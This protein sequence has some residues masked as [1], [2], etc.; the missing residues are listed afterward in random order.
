MS[1][2]ITIANV[3]EFPPNTIRYVTTEDD[4]SIL[5]SNINGAYYAIENMCTHDGGT[6]SE[7]HLEND[8]IVCPRHGAHFCLRNGAV[9]SPPAYEDVA[10]FATRILGDRVQVYD[11]RD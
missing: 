1:N 8:E 10:T 6:L 9:M 5:I 2:W 3:S 7:G 11:E 4:V